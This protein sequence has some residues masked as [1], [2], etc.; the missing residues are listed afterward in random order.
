MCDQPSLL[1]SHHE[2]LGVSAS[3]A[4]LLASRFEVIDSNLPALHFW[5]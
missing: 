2:L 3:D 1:E 5:E 4:F